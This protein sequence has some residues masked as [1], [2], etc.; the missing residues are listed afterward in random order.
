MVDGKDPFSLGTDIFATRASAVA[1][2]SLVRVKGASGKRPLESRSRRRR[3]K[4]CERPEW[5]AMTGGVH[6]STKQFGWGWDWDT[7]NLPTNP[8]PKLYIL[9]Y[10]SVIIYIFSFFF[11]LSLPLSRSHFFPFILAALRMCSHTC[12]PTTWSWTIY[13]KLQEYFRSNMPQEHFLNAHCSMNHSRGHNLKKA[14]HPGPNR[15]LIP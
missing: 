3:G 12:A 10:I 1:I 8:S 9:I 2:S 5:H 11:P 14:S 6:I 15:L 4:N 7:P 13:P